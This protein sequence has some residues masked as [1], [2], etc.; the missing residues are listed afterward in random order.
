MEDLKNESQELIDEVL[1][2]YSFFIP[3]DVLGDKM[4]QNFLSFYNI[5]L[6]QKFLDT[7]IDQ[8]LYFNESLEIKYL[9]ELNIITNY[10]N[11]KTL[12]LENNC[13]QLVHLKDTLGKASFKFIFNKYVKE[14]FV[15]S[16]LCDILIDFFYKY[17]PDNENNPTFLF[18][19]Q[20]MIL[21]THLNDI[22]EKI[23]FKSTKI[24]EKEI[25]MSLI[26]SPFVKP[27]IQEKAK[28]SEQITNNTTKIKKEKKIIIIRFREF[29]LHEK[30][31]EI[32]KIVKQHLSDLKGISLRYL[33]EYFVE[34]KLLIINTGDRTK[35]HK[36]FEALFE[37][38]NIGKYNS[39]FDIKYFTRKDPNY[40][41]SKI[42]FEKLFEKTIN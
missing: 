16:Y 21:E 39:V 2:N 41:K 3:Y 33:I 23:N 20:K 10:N 22:K 35:L 17:Y 9:E 24:N 32:E 18:S 26:N 11:R 37:G 13:F 27:Y 1:K 30:N 6:T 5:E 7:Y 36:S 12:K 40:I 14:V 31:D 29:V 19:Q 25:M 4:A 8:L 42:A 15:F 38:K 34:K 28:I